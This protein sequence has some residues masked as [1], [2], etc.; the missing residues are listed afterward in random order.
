MR[1]LIKNIISEKDKCTLTGFHQGILEWMR[2]ESVSILVNEK[3]ANTGLSVVR[4]V[5]SNSYS[6]FFLVELSAS[7]CM[8]S[9]CCKIEVSN[10]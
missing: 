4:S 8:G 10:T 2:I 9:N 5:P 7:N 1:I 3:V 6:H